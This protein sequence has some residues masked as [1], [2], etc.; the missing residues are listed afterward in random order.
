MAQPP[1][2]DFDEYS[3]DYREALEESIS[4]VRA[5]LDFF[6]QARPRR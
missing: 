5:D 4:F 3:D 1:Q 2:V 6:T